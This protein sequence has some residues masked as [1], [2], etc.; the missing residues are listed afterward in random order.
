M[1]HAKTWTFLDTKVYKGARFH[2]ES[3]LDVQTYCKPTE[4][5]QYTNVLL[6]SSAGV[7]KLKMFYQGRSIKVSENKFLRKIWKTSRNAFWI[8]DAQLLL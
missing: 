2:K 6:V 1:K 7:T 3:I 4:N 8:E 5:F